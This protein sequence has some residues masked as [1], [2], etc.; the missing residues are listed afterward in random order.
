MF[1]GYLACSTV[2]HLFIFVKTIWDIWEYTL[3]LEYLLYIHVLYLKN[4]HMTA[5]TVTGIC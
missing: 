1:Q 4:S 2:D 5:K 3:L